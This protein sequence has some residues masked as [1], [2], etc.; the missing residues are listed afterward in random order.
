MQLNSQ[1]EL[2]SEC[3]LKAKCHE[4]NMCAEG[5]NGLKLFGGCRV[6]PEF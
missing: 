4:K 3:A 1:E 2:K 6:S 5:Y